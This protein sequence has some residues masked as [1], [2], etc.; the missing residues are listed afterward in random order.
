MVQGIVT[1][2]GAADHQLAREIERVSVETHKRIDEQAAVIAA[3]RDL[4]DSMRM[5]WAK[6]AGAAAVVS[7]VVST[8]LAVGFGRLFGGG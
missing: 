5:A 3:Q 7:A 2:V 8:A 1:T 4:I 6:S